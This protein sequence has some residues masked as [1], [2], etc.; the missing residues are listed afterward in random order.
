MDSLPSDLD[1]TSPMQCVHQ[2]VFDLPAD[3]RTTQQKA[4][5]ALTRRVQ[6]RVQARDAA[7]SSSHNPR[8]PEVIPAPEF[9]ISRPIPGPA[10]SAGRRKR[11]LKRTISDYEAIDRINRMRKSREET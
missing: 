3:P 4:L 9:E 10:G 1:F 2:Q 11:N 6:D 7:S 8:P 5:K